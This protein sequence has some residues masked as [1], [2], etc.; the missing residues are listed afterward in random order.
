MNAASP[1]RTAWPTLV[2]PLLA[3]AILGAVHLPRPLHGDAALYQTGARVMANGG[4][5]YRDF[6]DQKQ[7]GIYLFHWVAG[8]SIAFSEVGLHALELGTLLGISLAQILFLRRH[9]TPSWLASLV[10]IASF[11]VYYAVTTDWHLTQ[12][13]VLLSAPLFTILAIAGAPARRT[14]AAWLLA[15]AATVAALSLK[16]M[17]APLIVLMLALGAW[18]DER[19]TPRDGAARARAV[20]RERLLPF[21]AGALL[22]GGVG[23]I[24]LQFTGGWDWYVWTHTSW[25]PEALL[26]RGA[27]PIDRVAE[28]AIWFLKQFAPWILLAAAAPIGWRGL[29]EER[30]FVVAALW[31]GFGGALVMIEPFAGWPFDTLMLIVPLGILAMRGV[32]G[33]IGAAARSA[34]FAR[35]AVARAPVIAA[36]VVLGAS[37]PGVVRWVPKARE[38][39]E[40]APRLGAPDF[41]YQRAID[42]RY[43]SA[44]RDTAFLREEESAQGAIYVF[45]DP[46]VALMSGRPQ[47]S[48]FHGWAWEIQ[49][50]PIWRRVEQDLRREQPPYIFV[51]PEEDAL[52][53][54]RGPGIRGLLAETY[55]VRTRDG[56]GTWYEAASP[57]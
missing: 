2:L 39:V 40:H 41:D 57:R 53:G 28:S 46:I 17:V 35:T 22:V 44:W 55:A 45:G 42:T 50:P 11:G 23:V 10:P 37:L 12:P 30:L 26:V 9:F 49:P 5:L 56:L 3:L 6:W 48:A 32:Q 43:A 25:R 27:H 51:A 19:D 16:S 36:A 54:E 4:T 15:G 8:R 34:S 7:P 13:A 52:I 31:L 29:R 38:F 20:V 24:L 47:A 33:M 1:P 21:V 14:R 18:F